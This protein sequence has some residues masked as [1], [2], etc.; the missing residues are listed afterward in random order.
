MSTIPLREVK[1]KWIFRPRFSYTR[2]MPDITLVLAAIDAGD[3][4]GRPLG[5]AGLLLQLAGA[6][7]GAFVA[8]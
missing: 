1:P 8:V 2:F 6:F 5:F 3:G 7:T 4:Q